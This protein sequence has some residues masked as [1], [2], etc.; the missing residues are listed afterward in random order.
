MADASGVPSVIMTAPSS[1]Y[2]SVERDVVA[3]FIPLATSLMPGLTARRLHGDGPNTRA[4]KC[5]VP[6]L[7]PLFFLSFLAAFCHV[8]GALSA[9]RRVFSGMR[10][11]TSTT[12][13]LGTTMQRAGSWCTVISQGLLSATSRPYRTTLRMPKYRYVLR[14]SKI[15]GGAGNGLGLRIY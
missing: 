10:R 12:P 8:H 1:P 3:V 4:T 7:T 11:T 13:S 15:V 2:A 9:K 14:V 5:K 6:N